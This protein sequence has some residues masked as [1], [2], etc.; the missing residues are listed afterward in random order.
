MNISSS[1]K[2][3]ATEPG[4]QCGGNFVAMKVAVVRKP[5]ANSNVNSIDAAISART[6]SGSPSTPFAD[7]RRCAN[8]TLFSSGT[9]L[10]YCPIRPSFDTSVTIMVR[11]VKFNSKPKESSG[12]F[13]VTTTTILSRNSMD[14]CAF[15]PAFT[16]LTIIRKNFACFR[17]RSIGTGAFCRPLIDV[18]VA[19]GSRRASGLSMFQSPMRP[20]PTESHLSLMT[21]SPICM[22][23]DWSALCRSTSTSIVSSAFRSTTGSPQR[24]FSSPVVFFSS[25]STATRSL[26]SMPLIL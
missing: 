10:L 16:F 25:S 11:V 17:T 14:F 3:V 20:S 12:L 13:F 5:S 23:S 19:P 9:V 22:P 4:P 26:P 15:F 1:K 21:S 7:S 6:R 8:C 2:V 24:I 18:K